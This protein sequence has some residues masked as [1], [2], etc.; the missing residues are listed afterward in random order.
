MKKEKQND[1]QML[2][3]EARIQTFQNWPFMSDCSCTPQKMAE[4]G[5]YTCGG[6][7][8][9]DLVRCYFCRKEL[10]NITSSNTTSPQLTL[11][12][13]GRL[14][15]RGRPLEGASKPCQA[16][17]NIMLLVS[18][19]GWAL[20]FTFSGAVPSNLFIFWN[21]IFIADARGTC[22]YINLN[23]KPDELTAVDVLGILEPE[24]QKKML[25]LV[26]DAHETE[27]RGNLKK[28][29]QKINK[30]VPRC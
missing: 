15:A 26:S 14:G 13:E 11:F 20:G 27:V 7:N 22:A 12:P 18:R 9:P 8:E 10:V 28:I 30:L 24:K 3:L 19:L 4:A 2:N 5:F 16:G 23:K 6:N 25:R 17:L 1:S 29:K 21:I